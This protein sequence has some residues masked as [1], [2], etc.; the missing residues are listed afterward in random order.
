MPQLTRPI[1]LRPL[2]HTIE[3]AWNTGACPETRA[4]DLFGRYPMF[5]QKVRKAF[6]RALRLGSGSIT[7][8][9]FGLFL[10]EEE[11]LQRIRE[12]MTGC[13]C[14]FTRF[15]LSFEREVDKLNHLLKQ[16]IKQRS[17]MIS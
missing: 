13:C 15:F 8:G 4:M 11:V 7:V 3:A 1:I 17:C 6:S 16:E 9:S 5:R 14:H 2:R 10:D 12:T